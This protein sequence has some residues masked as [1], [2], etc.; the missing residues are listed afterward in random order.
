[1]RRLVFI[2][3]CVSLVVLLLPAV[4]SAS[5]S[6][7]IANLQRAVA[8]LQSQ[9]STLQNRVVSLQ[10]QVDAKRSILIGTSAPTAATGRAGDLYINKNAWVIWGPKAASGANPWGSGTSLI[11]PTGP[12]G[13]RGIQGEQGLQG[14]KGDPGEAGLQGPKGDPGDPGT[15]GPAGKD[16]LSYSADPNYTSIEKVAGL[17]TYLT[18]T[19]QSLEGVAG[20]NIVFEGANVHIRSGLQNPTWGIP[21]PGVGNLIVGNDLPSGIDPVY[22]TGSNNLVVGDQHS[23]TGNGGFVAGIKNTVTGDYATV[24]GGG[25]NTASGGMATVSGGFGNTASGEGASVSG[26]SGNE[27]SVLGATIGGGR[28]ILLATLFS[29]AAGSSGT[30]GS[31]TPFTADWFMTLGE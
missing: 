2:I 13:P 20:P 9:V 31:K 27:A 18:I 10:S 23:F 14:P 15:Q 30:D 19:D 6:T 5:T 1:M 11:G 12:Q 22:R 24:S 17:A 16:G 8:T 26:G 4:A 7:D 29:W 3:I 21:F 28:D 25:N